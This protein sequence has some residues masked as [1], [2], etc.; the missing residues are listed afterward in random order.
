MFFHPRVHHCAFLNVAFYLDFR[1][2]FFLFFSLPKCF[3]FIYLFTKETMNKTKEMMSNTKTIT[4]TMNN[5]RS[6]K[7]RSNK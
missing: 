1:H 3:C 7:K 2:L 4:K 6:T 5:R